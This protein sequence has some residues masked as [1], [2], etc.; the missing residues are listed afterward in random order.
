MSHPEIICDHCFHSGQADEEEEEE[1]PEEELNA[2]IEE[3]HV[4]LQSLLAKYGATDAS[5]DPEGIHMHVYW[6]NKRLPS[7]L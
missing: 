1:D 6:V 5:G 4:P 3:A 7:S 2:L